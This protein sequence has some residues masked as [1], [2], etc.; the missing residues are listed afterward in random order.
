MSFY[1][2]CRYVY[3]VSIEHQQIKDTKE[4]VSELIACRLENLS[5]VTVFLLALLVPFQ[6]YR[7]STAIFN[8]YAKSPHGL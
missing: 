5:H 6:E 1:F 3:I 4:R 8:D 2:S 7:N